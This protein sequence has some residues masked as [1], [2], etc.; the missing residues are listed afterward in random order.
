M[1][2]ISEQLRALHCTE[3]NTSQT[4][5]VQT[6]PEYTSRKRQKC[7]IGQNC[8]GNKTVDKCQNCLK[9]ACGKCTEKVIK[10]ITCVKCNH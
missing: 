7:Q 4:S 2:A 1:R 9:F 10:T 6:E 5:S 3:K 8:K